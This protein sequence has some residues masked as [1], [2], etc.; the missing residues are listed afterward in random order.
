[1]FE[2]NSV[3]KLIIFKTGGPLSKLIAKILHQ[4]NYKRKA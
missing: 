3:F 2:I 4:Q 1:M